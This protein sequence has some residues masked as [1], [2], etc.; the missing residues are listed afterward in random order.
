MPDVS[1]LRKD[2]GLVEN[3]KI[4][5]ASGLVVGRINENILYTHNDSGGRARIF[6]LTG[7]GAHV[8]TIILST[9]VNRDWEDLAIGVDP[10]DKET[11]IYIAD[12]GDNDKRYI[13]DT[14]YRFKEVKLGQDNQ[15]KILIKASQLQKISFKYPD[16]IYD[17]ETLLT[18]PFTGE[19]FVITK[20]RRNGRL[21][22]IP[23]DFEVDHIVTAKFLCNVPVSKA[24]GG[25]FSSDG[26]MIIVKNYFFVYFWNI[27]DKQGILALAQSPHITPYIPEP[28]GEAIAFDKSNKGYF[29][30]SEER[31]KIPAHLYHFKL[32]QK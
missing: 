14:I 17:A 29:T 31:K 9:G 6:A 12:I 25:D 32:T 7:E 23:H 26:T 13:V 21:Y 2:C 24:T 20:S 18:H 4:D 5:E 3:D 22:Q 19:I 16:G 10:D 8:T 28:Q 15:R 1:T 11:Y 30:L 27:S